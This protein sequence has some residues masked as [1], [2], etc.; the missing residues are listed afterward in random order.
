V[1]I[2]KNI[3]ILLPDRK[4]FLKLIDSTDQILEIMAFISSLFISALGITLLNKSRQL[5]DYNTIFSEYG[6]IMI[7]VGTGL[8][9]Y[10]ITLIL[11]KIL[12][13][14]KMKRT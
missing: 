12:S 4:R 6:T 9:V 2:I 1:I 3:R 14:K 11:L 7:W 10:T 5:T 13:K 8:F